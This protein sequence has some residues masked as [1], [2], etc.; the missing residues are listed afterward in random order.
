MIKRFLP[1]VAITALAACS[2]SSETEQPDA[3]ASTSAP[4]PASG[5]PGDFDGTATGTLAPV[6]SATGTPPPDHVGDPPPPVAGVDPAARRIALA[7]WRKSE[8][9]G[10]C[11]PLAL[12]SDAGAGGKAR[13]ANFSGGWGVAFDQP[14]LRSAYGIAGTGFL[15]EDTQ[16]VTKQRAR[17]AAQWPY[18]RELSQLPEPS[19]AGYGVEGAGDYPKTNPDGNGLNSIAY[20]RVGGQTCDYNVWSRLGRAHLE[21]LLEN[22]VVLPT[23]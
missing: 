5:T 17:L 8:K 12:K 14:G 6:D 23:G 3:P 15:P 20:V 16:S 19:F 11:G 9:P 13:R 22:L 4:S 7:E 1:A 10:T 21:H 2:S 18:F